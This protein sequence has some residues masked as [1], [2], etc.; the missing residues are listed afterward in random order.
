MLSYCVRWSPYLLQACCI[1]HDVIRVVLLR[2]VVDDVL[3]VVRVAT[4]SAQRRVVS[5]A[6]HTHGL[7]EQSDTWNPFAAITIQSREYLLHNPL[8]FLSSGQPR[9]RFFVLLQLAEMVNLHFLSLIEALQ[10]CNSS[11]LYKLF[12]MWLPVFHSQQ[13]HV[14]IFCCIFKYS[15]ICYHV[16]VLFFQLQGPVQLRLQM[17]QNWEPKEASKRDSSAIDGEVLLRWLKRVQFKLGQI[18]VQSSTATQFYTVWH[19]IT[20]SFLCLDNSD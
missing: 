19:V 10:E 15:H 7:L 5:R 20:C 16:I 14:F 12:P 18:E 4:S 2:A 3:W 6:H 8:S 1:F 9:A 17:C 13:T 11:V